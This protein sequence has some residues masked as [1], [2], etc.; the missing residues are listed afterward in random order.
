MEI[1]TLKLVEYDDEGFEEETALKQNHFFSK[2]AALDHVADRVP[3]GLTIKTDSDD[4]YDGYSTR[5]ERVRGRMTDVISA[6]VNIKR[7]DFKPKSHI[8]YQA[9]VGRINDDNKDVFYGDSVEE[10]KQKVMDKYVHWT[11][12]NLWPGSH[13]RLEIPLIRI[14]TI[15]VTK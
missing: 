4:E 6:R 3:N 2:Q 10:L 1:Y 12:S 7:I 5:K 13:L 15:E 11:K 9:L 8:F 14:F